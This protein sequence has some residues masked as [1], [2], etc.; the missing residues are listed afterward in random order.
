LF[1]INLTP[2]A[3]SKINELCK[4]AFG[5]HLGMKGGGCAGFE[6]EWTMIQKEDV[7]V[8]DEIINCGNGNL[9]IDATSLMYLFGCEI[10]YV[11]DVFQTQFVINNPNAQSSC[12]C[13]VSVNFDLDKVE[14]NAKITELT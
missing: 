1:A 13:G 14:Q 8:N 10:D 5:V 7:G 6:Y 4:D 12:G 11:T 3:K 9:V 2:T